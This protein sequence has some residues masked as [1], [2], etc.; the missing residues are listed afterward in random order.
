MTPAEQAVIDAAE[1]WVERI[2]DPP[3][4]WADDEDFALI[5]ALAALRLERAG[6]PEDTY[7]QLEAEGW[8]REVLPTG[9]VCFQYGDV[10]FYVPGPKRQ[11]HVDMHV[12][13]G[14]P[15]EASAVRLARALAALI[16]DA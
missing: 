2:V 11:W 12:R 4:L 8:M 15:D 3:N 5:S 9:D 16:G 13:A 1:A 14:R 7:E 10:W 6:T